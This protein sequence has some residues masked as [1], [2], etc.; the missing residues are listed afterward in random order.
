MNKHDEKS[1]KTQQNILTYGNKVVNLPKGIE[2]I[3]RSVMQWRFN[4]AGKSAV[5]LSL[6][7]S[8]RLNRQYRLRQD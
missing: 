4:V 6:S 2:K 5:F 8:I 1:A 7:R 3:A